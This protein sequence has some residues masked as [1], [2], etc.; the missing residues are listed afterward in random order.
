VPDL[1]PPTATVLDSFLR[2]MAEFRA[3]GR[4][5][6]DD[7]TMIGGDLRRYADTWHTPDG[8]ASYLADLRED[9]DHPRHAGW[10]TCTTWWWTDGAEFLG[11]IAVRHQLTDQLRI[12]GGHIG[13]DVRPT[14]R[15]QGHATSMLRA[16][17]RRAPSLGVSPS[18]LITCDTTNIGSR[19]A[20]ETNGGVLADETDGIRRYWVPTA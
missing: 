3:E 4:G 5:T 1:V 15:R 10:V 11:R 8:F 16:A 2:A 7:H 20:I 19:K 6:E 17:L 14:A 9:A 13:Y 18:A 12:A